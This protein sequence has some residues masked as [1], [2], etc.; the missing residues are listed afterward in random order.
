MN[1]IMAKSA[2][3]LLNSSNDRIE[4]E[5]GVADIK[6][7][8]YMR[9]FSGDVISRACFG[10]SYA[11]GEEIFLKLRA[12]QE[13]LSKKSWSKGIPSNEV[14]K[15]RGEVASEEDLLQMI[16]ESATSSDLSQEAMDRFIVD[17]CKNIYLVGYETTAVDSWDLPPLSLL[18][19][20][21]R[22]LIRKKSSI[23]RSRGATALQ[24]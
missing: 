12:R 17:N 8:E 1:I 2:V 9:S 14:V 22:G 19:Y 15:E 23:G 7:D 13:A 21:P 16:L 3:T 5:G 11:E 20:T 10:S 18:G 24:I 4:N 6:I